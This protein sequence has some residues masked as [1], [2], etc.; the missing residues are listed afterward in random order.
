MNL[1]QKIYKAIQKGL[2]EALTNLSIED[3]DDIEMTP[4]NTFE[5]EEIMKLS[6]IDEYENQKW[7]K[8]N[9]IDLN[10]PSGTKWCKWN[11]GATNY[12]TPEAWFGNYYS[13]GE[14]KPKIEFFSGNYL[15]EDKHPEVLP[16][17]DDAAY[18]FDNRMRMPTHEE[19][20]ELLKYT[21]QEWIT[22]YDGISDLSGMLFTGRN[23]N[24]IFF[25]AAGYKVQGNKIWTCDRG[26]YWSSSID[27][28]DKDFEL[29]HFLHV[30]CKKEAPDNS[31]YRFAGRSVRGVLR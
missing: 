1:G 18:Q 6:G 28:D 25:P 19:I 23:N 15:Y 2:N 29:A 11:L 9:F 27:M 14:I 12:R 17:Q 16:L 31:W 26:Y 22:D 8:E 4:D 3:F 24:S 30:N 5:T 13:W 10:L 21:S 7:I 20:Q